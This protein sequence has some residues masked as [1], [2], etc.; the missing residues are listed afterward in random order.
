[1]SPTVSRLAF[2]LVLSLSASVAACGGA[3][4]DS[5]RIA[6]S[7]NVAAS[8]GRKREVEVFARRPKHGRGVFKINVDGE[9]FT[10]LREHA[11]GEA[12]TWIFDEG[13]NFLGLGVNR[14]DGT[15]DYLTASF[16]LVHQPIGAVVPTA[17][18]AMFESAAWVVL[19]ADV[20]KTLATLEKPAGP[21]GLPFAKPTQ[22]V[23]FV[24]ACAKCGGAVARACGKSSGDTTVVEACALLCESA[25]K[26]FLGDLPR[27]P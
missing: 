1:M 13:R 19:G 26:C 2:S 9:S 5:E 8:D 25:D 4:L 11:R 16:V 17:I 23:S 10:V 27:L 22:A 12:K 20:Q 21:V 24:D 3:E 7:M 14:T 6:G 15:V 18:A